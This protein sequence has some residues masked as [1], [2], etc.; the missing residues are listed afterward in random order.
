MRLSGRSD[1]TRYSYYR[2]VMRM[3]LY[4]DHRPLLELG[5]DDT[6]GTPTLASRSG[7]TSI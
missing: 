5:E 7:C 6:S 2:A 3:D 1:A 4:F